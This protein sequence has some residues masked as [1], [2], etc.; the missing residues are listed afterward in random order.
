MNSNAR[1]VVP[2]ITYHEYL[3]SVEGRWNPFIDAEDWEH[4]APQPEERVCL[5]DEEFFN[6][7][8]DD[9]RHE[10]LLQALRD[11]NTRWPDQGEAA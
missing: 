2:S 6:A 9:D 10:L 3:A 7:L 1:L 5:T 4:F 8:H 11:I